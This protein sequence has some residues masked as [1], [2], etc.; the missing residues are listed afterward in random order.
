MA[1]EGAAVFGHMI[2]KY[3]VPLVEAEML[4]QCVEMTLEKVACAVIDWKGIKGAN[5]PWLLEALKE[6]GL[7]YKKV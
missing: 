1:L 2:P 3:A 4:R 6:I 5:K 7:P